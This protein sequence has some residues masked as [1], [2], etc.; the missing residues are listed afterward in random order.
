M[1][2]G[3]SKLVEDPFAPVNILGLES[4]LADYGKNL[5]L[6]AADS[7]QDQAAFSGALTGLAGSLGKLDGAIAKATA[8]QRL[9]GDD[10]LGA[11]AS[12]VAR[13]GNL[14]FAAQRKRALKRIIVAAQPLVEEAVGV[15]NE[16]DSVVQDYDITRALQ[17]ATDAENQL[18]DV[19]KERPSQK[20]RVRAAQDELYAAVEAVN[21]ITARKKRI[22]ELGVVHAALATAARKGSSRQDLEAAENL[23]I[24]WNAQFEK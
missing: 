23:L 13:V 17:R 9:S 16:A 11:I 2:D 4:A 21:S 7:S 3:T 18:I 15:L 24:R 1:Q 12:V 19:L 6:L 5:A 14:I 10:K 20:P 8:G 22:R